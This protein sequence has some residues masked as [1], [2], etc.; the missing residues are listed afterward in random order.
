ML[1][2]KNTT[3]HAYVVSTYIE[4]AVFI[5]ILLENNPRVSKAAEDVNAVN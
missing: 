5:E 2:T 1:E 3:R 4:R